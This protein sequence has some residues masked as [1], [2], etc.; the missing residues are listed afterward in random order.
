MQGGRGGRGQGSSSSDGSSSRSYN[1]KQ[2]WLEQSKQRTEAIKATRSPEQL[3]QFVQQH[4]AQF[5]HVNLSAAYTH[6]VKLCPQGVPPQQQPAAVQ[7]LL[8]VLHRLAEQLQGKCVARQLANIVW[9]CGHLGTADTAAML[10]PVFLHDSILHHPEPQHVSNVLWA[11]ATLGMQLTPQ[12]AQQLLQHFEQVLPLAK[13]QNVSNVLW[14]A[15]TLELHLTPQQLQQMLQHF[16]EVLPQAN[17][18]EIA[19]TLWAVAAMQQQVPLQQLQQM[20]QR[21]QVVLPQAN[22][23]NVANTLWACAKLLYA[24]LQLLSALEQHPQQLQAVLA[25]AGSHALANMTWACGQLGYRG[26]L[27]PGALLQ[28]AATQLRGSTCNYVIQALCNLCWSAAVLD[29]QQCVPQVLQLAAASSVLWHTGVAESLLQLYQVHLWLLDSQLPAPGQGLSGVLSQQQLEQCRASWLQQLAANAQQQVSATHGTVLV[30]V[31]QLP[32]GTWQ[33]QPESEGVT[34]DGLFSV[35]IAATTATGV[36]VAIEVDGPSHFIQ[37]LRTV[38]GPTLC[39]N[40]TLAA[41][42]YVVVSIPY[43][44]W[45]TLRGVEPKQQYLLAKLQP[46]LQQQQQQ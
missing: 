35:D 16:Q 26:K 13:P 9:S 37:P 46:A 18:Q 38:G 40:R 2:L 27:L 42:G 10:L 29:L 3:L 4:A 12:Q 25:A 14:A 23:Q 43:W 15:A 28:Q 45:E 17:P 11:A 21:F 19:N 33:R 7:Q 30:A 41:R 1:A 6:A 34:A 24:P 32:S 8:P 44:E 39:R 22:P 31:Q 20:L 36:K 5:T